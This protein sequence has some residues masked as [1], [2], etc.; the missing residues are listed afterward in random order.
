VMEEDRGQVKGEEE[1]KGSEKRKRSSERLPRSKDEL[2][3]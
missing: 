2:R 3:H 1:K